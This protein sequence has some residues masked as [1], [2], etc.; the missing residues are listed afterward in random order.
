MQSLIAEIEPYI[1][2]KNILI[3]FAANV[4]N[5][6]TRK[7]SELRAQTLLFVMIHFRMR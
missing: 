5:L 6:T 1:A 2:Y 3:V 4:H 7:S